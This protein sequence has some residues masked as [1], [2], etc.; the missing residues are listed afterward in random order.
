LARAP[1]FNRRI[2]D[3]GPIGRRRNRGQNGSRTPLG[4]LARHRRQVRRFNDLHG[5]A[6]P[7]QFAN[8]LRSIASKHYGHADPRQVQAI[9]SYSTEQLRDDHDRIL[10]LFAAKTPQERRVAEM[11]A[12]V[13]LAGEIAARNQIVPWTIATAR[14]YADS[15]SVNAAVAMFNRWKESRSDSGHFSGEQDKILSSIRDYIERYRESRFS[16]IDATSFVT[17]GGH[18]IDAPRINDRAGYWEDVGGSR[19]YLFTRSGLREATRGFNFGRVLKALADVGALIVT[20]SDGEKAKNRRTPDGGQT[21]LYHIDPARLERVWPAIE[22]GS[23][24]YV[25]YVPKIGLLKIPIFPF[26]PVV[27]AEREKFPLSTLS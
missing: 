9:L 12:A 3:P 21:R 5:V 16:N 22:S 18:V 11:F 23:G 2:L 1:F 14:D 27:V 25:C 6:S 15:D 7:A 13:G 4:R 26:S 8:E 17:P 10:G 24:C 20:G 19:S